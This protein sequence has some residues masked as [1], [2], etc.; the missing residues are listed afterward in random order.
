[1][2]DAMKKTFTTL[3][4]MASFITLANAT[5]FS[6]GDQY[7]AQV[8]S[9]RLNVSCIGSGPGP[10]FGTA[11]CHDEILN[12]G[13]YA[14]FEGPKVDA[15]KVTLV[16]TRENGSI[17]KVKTSD[18]DSATAKSKK[19]FNLWISTVLQR[20]LLDYGKNTVTYTLSKNGNNV[21]QGT[22]MVEVVKGEKAVCQR[23][24]FYTSSNS[25]D[26]QTPDN[27]CARYFNENNYC[28]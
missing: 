22:F 7:H 20:P 17:S 24:G 8:I 15:D 28:Q 25:A 27:L 23:V 1:M 6:G 21:E 3:I 10:T 19:S 5:G 18:Y 2:E 13:E 12:P 11:Y 14:Y 16:A 26:C 9:G 4:T